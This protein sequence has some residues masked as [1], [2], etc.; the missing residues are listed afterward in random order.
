L[1]LQER[2]LSG[3][4]I[5]FE[6]IA[7][8]QPLFGAELIPT[9]GLSDNPII[10][11]DRDIQSRRQAVQIFVFDFAVPPPAMMISSRFTL[12]FV[13]KNA[14]PPQ[15]RTIAQRH[16]SVTVSHGST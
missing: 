10:A 14:N 7:L 5:A 3:E 4:R 11:R 1:K 12:A 8:A 6:G 13:A 15:G 16:S 2:L 9:G